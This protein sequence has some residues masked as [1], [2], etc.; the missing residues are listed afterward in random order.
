MP[1][2]YS[3]VAFPIVSNC[4]R[5]GGDAAILASGGNIRAIQIADNPK[6]RGCRVAAACDNVGLL[7]WGA[8]G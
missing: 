1:R 7:H 2:E 4:C 5:S 8:A 3:A 6:N